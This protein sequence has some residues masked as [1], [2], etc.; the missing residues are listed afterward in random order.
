MEQMAATPESLKIDED[1]NKITITNDTGDVTNLYPD[2]K[3]LDVLSTLD[4]GRNGSLAIR[5]VYDSGK[6]AAGNSE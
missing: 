5:R 2:G 4:Y 1:E 3:Q 6:A